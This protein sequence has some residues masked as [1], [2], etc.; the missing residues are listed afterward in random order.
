MS[1]VDEIVYLLDQAFSGEGIQ[2]TN[3]SQSLLA[4]LSS[5]DDSMWSTSPPR[6]ARTIESI[7]LHVGG[8]K[9]MYDDYAFGSGKLSWGEVEVQPWPLGE[10]PMSE[11]IAWLTRVHGR[12]VDH[13]GQLDDADL[14]SSRR[15]N[16]GEQ[17]QT[18][19]LISMLLQ[20]DT[21]HAGEANHVRSLLARDDEWKW[22]DD[23]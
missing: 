20:H 18:R 22:A 12:L 10:A 23:D 9:I 13:I 6:G 7:A 14:S 4:N 15:T 16:W 1:A 3:E 5:V 11:T 19:W 21:Y 2:E 17:A 8:C